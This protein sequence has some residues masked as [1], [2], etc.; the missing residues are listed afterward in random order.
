M[1]SKYFSRQLESFDC[2]PATLSML[3]KYKWDINITISQLKN[4]CYTSKNGTNFLGLKRALEALDI[5]VSVSKYKPSLT[6]LKSI[7]FPCIT[8]VQKENENHFIT[9]FKIDSKKIWLG[10]PSKTKISTLSHEKFLQRWIP[11]VLEVSSIN[12]PEII[13][14]YEAK[15]SSNLIKKSLLGVKK[16][17]IYSWVL[18]IISY[19]TVLISSTMFSVYF[20]RIIPNKYSRLLV[21][22]TILYL[23]VNTLQFVIN[24]L[25]EKIMIKSRNN[26]DKYLIKKLIHVYLHQDLPFIKLFNS[27]ELISR[28]RNIG[29]VRMRYYFFIQILPLEIITILVTLFLLLRTN[30]ILALLSLLPVLLFFIFYLYAKKHYIE[31]SYDLY[32]QEEALNTKLIETN[33]NIET[34]KSYDMVSSSERKLGKL[35][36]KFF[37]TREQFTVFASYQ[38]LIKNF[39]INMFNVGLFSLGC[40][41]V[42][43]NR[44]S[45]GIL[46]MFNSLIGYIFE[47][48]LELSNTQ[49]TLEQGKVALLRYSDIVSSKILS[50]QNKLYTL[51]NPIHSIKLKDVCYSYN[52]Y[53]KTLKNINLTI[54][55]SEKIALI[56]ESGSGK[57]TLAKIIAGYYPVDSGD[58]LINSEPLTAYDKND[59]TDKIKYIPHSPQIFND[60]ILN[61]I[62]LN[63]SISEEYIISFCKKIGLHSIISKLPNQYHTVIGANGYTLSTGQSQLLNIVR[64]IIDPPDVLILDE[65]TNGMDTNIKQTILQYIL[66]LDSTVILITHDKTA[67]SLFNKQLNISDGQIIP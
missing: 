51:N 42:I 13:Q 19:L 23:G 17:I 2:G 62:K 45:A 21:I 29:D 1:D 15:S 11:I 34:I 67:S 64:G 57:S 66:N 18:S 43:T 25:N 47:P 54:E 28:I 44:L 37:Q 4:L 46:L 26:I 36:N 40:Y 61:N 59:L 6:G 49:S 14:K 10:D 39:V 58:I 35:I 9:I 12:N 33:S 22:A 30:W 50:A 31:I 8:Q 16:Y 53:T 55:N 3:L 24:L 5:N 52:I 32:N 63:R 20:D 7:V 48:F 60:T 56:G 27:G 65:I 38:N 41:L